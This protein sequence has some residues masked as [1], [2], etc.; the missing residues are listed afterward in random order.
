VSASVPVCQWLHP[1]SGDSLFVD[2]DLKTEFLQPQTHADIR[3]RQLNAGALSCMNLSF[4]RPVRM[5]TAIAARKN[6]P[7]QTTFDPKK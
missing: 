2:N 4:E 6:E 5:K 7:G 1:S 3:R